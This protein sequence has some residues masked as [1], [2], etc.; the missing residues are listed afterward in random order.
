[1]RRGHTLYELLVT[2]TVATV[3]LVVGVPSL[4]AF[5]ARG[6]QVTEINALHH[7]I[8]R[9]RSESIMRRRYMSLCPSRDGEQCSES[10]DWSSGWL[11]FEN[12]DRD[13]PA[14]VDEGESI[15]D[16]HYVHPGIR[17]TANRVDFTVRGTRRRST[18]GTLV[19]C[20]IADR[21]PPRALVVSYTGRPRAAETTPSGARYECP[22]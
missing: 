19:A 10:R 22:G 16:R 18:N 1:M 11:L 8:H 6:R 2:I 17:L 4:G 15:L 5:V 3:V 7:A 13:S 9:A 21:A 14:R 12:L 20:D